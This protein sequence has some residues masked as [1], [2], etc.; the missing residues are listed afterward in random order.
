MTALVGGVRQCMPCSSLIISEMLLE[1]HTSGLPRS[2]KNVWKMKFFPGQGKVREFCGWSGKLRKDLESQG[3][4][5][6]FENKWLWQ[7]DFR[8]LFT[9]FKSGKAV[10]SHEIV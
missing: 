6:E 10:L 9:L 5:R 2:G 3:K 7:A 8:S 4:V 1:I